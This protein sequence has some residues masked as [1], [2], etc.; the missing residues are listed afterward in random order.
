M[1]SG[2]KMIEVA[3]ESLPELMVQLALL[4]ASDDG[5]TSPALLIALAVTIGA[6]AIL[7]TD[8]APQSAPHESTMNPTWA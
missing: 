5:W 4:L 2:L 8:A 3:C 6:A 7:S 1:L